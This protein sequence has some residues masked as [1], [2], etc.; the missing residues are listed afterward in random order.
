MADI[1]AVIAE[2]AVIAGGAVIAGAEVIA[3]AAVIAEVAVTAE[4]VGGEVGVMVTIAGLVMD[5][6]YG[7]FLLMVIMQHHA[8]AG[9]NTGLAGAVRTGVAAQIFAVA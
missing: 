5:I 9:V 7:R 3:E 2:V 4:A 1:A 6:R 8:M